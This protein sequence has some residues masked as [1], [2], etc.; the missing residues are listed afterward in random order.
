[1]AMH[2]NVSQRYLVVALFYYY[3]GPLNII[4]FMLTGSYTLSYHTHYCCF[5]LIQWFRSFC[6]LYTLHTKFSLHQTTCFFPLL[7]QLPIFKMPHTISTLLVTYFGGGT[8]GGQ[9][10][11]R[12]GNSL[13]SYLSGSTPNVHIQMLM[14]IN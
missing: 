4:K 8:W 9:T 14:L 1:M 12:I 3:K 5:L 2:I 7:S 11:A 6:F 10:G 13:P